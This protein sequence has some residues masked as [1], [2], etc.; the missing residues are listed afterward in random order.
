MININDILETIN[1]IKEE[2]LEADDVQNDL[3]EEPKMS[4]KEILGDSTALSYNQ[5]LLDMVAAMMQLK[6]EF[7]DENVR[8]LS[9]DDWQPAMQ[10]KVPM[11]I[12][13]NDLE[14]GEEKE[15]RAITSEQLYNLID[16]HIDTYAYY[17]AVSKKEERE[18]EMRYQAEQQSQEMEN[19]D[20]EF[21]M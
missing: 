9:Y 11:D 10:K 21:F 18:E 8:I 6:K 13:V 4:V 2:N 20:N 17:E 19:E 1:M 5:Q 12:L 7:V 15:L 16:N 14:L 3:P